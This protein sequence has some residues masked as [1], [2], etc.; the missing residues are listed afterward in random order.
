MSRLRA[1]ILSSPGSRGERYFCKAL[2]DN[3]FDPEVL[4]VQEAIDY[5]IDFEQLCSKYQILVLPG[6]NTYGSVFGGGKALSIKIQ[7]SLKWNLQKFAD[8]GGLV[9]GVGTGFQTL[10]HL[11]IFGD[12]YALRLNEDAQS[13]E[14]WL[15]AIPFG[16]RCVWL[17]G[18][19]TVELPMNQLDTEFV[20][21]PGA[22][23]EAKGRLERLGMSCL[24][25]ETQDKIYG[26]CDITGRI[27]GLLPHPEYFLSWTNAEDWYLT[28]SRAAAPGQ[29]FS[30]FENA[31]KHFS[32]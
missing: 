9:L 30:L 21:D 24:R 25:G 8:R 29:G 11:K 7:Y 18:L 15:K 12:D 28:P 27:F 4:D 6:G 31:A 17:R 14:V 10:L 13:K 32:L 22:Y 5:R 20:I 16:S 1:L 23:V 3:G 26:L 19:G 2:K